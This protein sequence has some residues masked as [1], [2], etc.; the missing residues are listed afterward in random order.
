MLRW[1]EGPRERGCVY[2][3]QAT[4]PLGRDSLVIDVFVMPDI[5]KIRPIAVTLGRYQNYKA[6]KKGKWQLQNPNDLSHVAEEVAILLVNLGIPDVRASSLAD[7]VES[8]LRREASNL[9]EAL[10]SVGDIT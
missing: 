1:R 8:F 4:A 7:E 6:I 3:K 5:V 2:H 10:M 9:R